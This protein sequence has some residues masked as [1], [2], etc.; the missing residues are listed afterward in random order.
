MSTVLNLLLKLAKS[1]VNLNLI[2]SIFTNL[3]YPQGLLFFCFFSISSIFTEVFK[4]NFFVV[5]LERSR[6]GHGLSQVVGVVQSVAFMPE[7]KSLKHLESYKLSNELYH[8]I[9][10]IS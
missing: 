3:F 5:R 10:T 8:S 9:S 2:K 1:L 7:P 4:V 6:F